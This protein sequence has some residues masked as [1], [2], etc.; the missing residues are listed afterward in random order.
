[1]FS[2]SEWLLVAAVL[3]AIIV[4][5]MAFVMTGRRLAAVPRSWEP[6]TSNDFRRR[7]GFI[8]VAEGLV[9]ATLA[10]EQREALLKR[11]RITTDKQPADRRVK[12]W[13]HENALEFRCRWTGREWVPAP[14]MFDRAEVWIE[15][16]AVSSEVEQNRQNAGMR[17]CDD[18]LTDCENSP[19]SST[20][21]VTQ[22]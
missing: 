8:K 1:M 13:P 19:R 12:L 16:I 14:P 15:G 21:T 7:V 11:L 22:I 2:K 6:N 20:V 18:E 9:G 5:I 17:D 4:A 10:H 3:F